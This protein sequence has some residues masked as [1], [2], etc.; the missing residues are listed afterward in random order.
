MH[1]LILTHRTQPMP[2]VSVMKTTMEFQMKSYF[3]IL[4]RPK[5]WSIDNDMIKWKNSQRTRDFQ[6][7]QFVY[8]FFL[9][10]QLYMS[11]ANSYLEPT[12]DFYERRNSNILSRLIK[13]ATTGRAFITKKFTPPKIRA[14][15]LYQLLRSCRE[16]NQH[17]N[18][19]AWLV[20]LFI[21]SFNDYA[22]FSLTFP[23][24]S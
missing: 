21:S 1:G 18:P 16:S 12:E 10:Q 22:N 8:S 11:E 2:Q 17:S 3:I 6:T 9:W 13:C 5:T 19:T 24:E 14:A 7:H 4:S 23:L 20:L 15:G